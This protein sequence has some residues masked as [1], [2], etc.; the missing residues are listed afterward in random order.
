MTLGIQF[1]KDFTFFKSILMKTKLAW[2][3]LFLD[4]FWRPGLRFS[5]KESE[6]SNTDAPQMIFGLFWKKYIFT[7]ADNMINNDENQAFF[8]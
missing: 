8:N 4:C 1:R 6:N 2:N 5:K 7:V 3:E